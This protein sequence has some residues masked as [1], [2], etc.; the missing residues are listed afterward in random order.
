M[1]ITVKPGKFN[2][3]DMHRDDQEKN[4]LGKQGYLLSRISITCIYKLNNFIKCGRH[5][6][7]NTHPLKMADVPVNY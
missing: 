5:L 6:F 7:R 2:S 4:I 1:K 3:F